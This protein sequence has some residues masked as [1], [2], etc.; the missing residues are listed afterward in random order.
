MLL[1][2]GNLVS[3]SIVVLGCTDA[4]GIL[5]LCNL[6][7]TVGFLEPE[8]RHLRMI[9][10]RLLS[11]GYGMPCERLFTFSKAEMKM[12]LWYRIILTMWL[13]GLNFCAGFNR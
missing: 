3:S 12:G 9:S 5:C 11:C 13:H 8:D 6:Q 1:G 7:E 10:A 4:S 2:L